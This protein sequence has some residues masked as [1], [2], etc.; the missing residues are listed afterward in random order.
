MKNNART[1]NVTRESILKLLSDDEVASVCTSE[2]KVCLAEQ[3]EYI[4]LEQ[5]ERG[6]QK[7]HGAGPAMGRML[8]RKAVHPDTWS[9]IL[10]ALAAFRSLGAASG[11]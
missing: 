4:D 1:E 2:T 7:S 3:D 10:T 5:L 9:K 6:V 11:K 8:P